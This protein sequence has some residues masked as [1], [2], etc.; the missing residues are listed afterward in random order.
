MIKNLSDDQIK[1]ILLNGDYV[2]QEDVDLADRFAKSHRSSIVSYFL[3][4]GMIDRDLLGQ[5]VAEY[6]DVSYAD[7]NSIQPSAEQVLK[8]PA[9]LAKKYQ[10]ILFKDGE[11]EVVVATDNP[12]QSEI[13]GSLQGIF[14]GKKITLAYAL[15]EDIEALFSHYRETLDTRFSKIIEAGVDFAPD[16]IDEIVDDALTYNASDIHF[17]PYEKEVV[18]RFRVDGVLREAGSIPKEYY[19]NILNKIKIDAGLRIDEHFSPQDGSMQNVKGDKKIDMRISIAPSRHGE[20][21]VIRI[22]SKYVESLSLESLGI[23][24]DNQKIIKDASHNP[25]G[26]ILVAGPTGSGKTTTLYALL[27]DLNHPEVNITTIEDPVEYEIS[28]ATQIQVNIQAGLDF[29]TGLRSIV[30]QDPDIILVGE[31]RDKDT[32]EISVNAALTGHLL[33]STFHANNS[34]TVVPRLMDIGVEPFLISSTVELII[35]QRLMRKICE[36]CRVSYSESKSEINNL[37]GSEKSFVDNSEEDVTLY[38]GNGCY[39]CGHTGYQGRVAVM[40]IIRA[41]S[42]M[43]DLI[44]KN[45]SSGQIWELAKSQ[46]SLSMFDDG[47]EKIKAGVTTIEELLRVVPRGK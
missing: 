15:S 45:P 24:P 10:A 3:S 8:I 39:M 14:V 1:N 18:V 2:T 40:E 32:A 6:F 38:K 30:R 21:I 47:V 22:L 33:L 46:G 43:R 34:A 35:A 26:M 41:T 17:G 29:A 11:D 12:S 19:E 31:I 5:A 7:L 25:F 42:E 27:R 9:N 13:L 37:L 16:F 44:L 36:N 28:G 20:K 4:E 23:S